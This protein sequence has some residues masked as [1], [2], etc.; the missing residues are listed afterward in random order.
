M[1]TGREGPAGLSS[2]QAPLGGSA[3]RVPAERAMWE[4]RVQLVSLATGE[5]PC[6]G[7]LQTCREAAAPACGWGVTG[8]GPA[9]LQVAEGQVV[10][11][12]QRLGS[13]RRDPLSPVGGTLF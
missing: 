1:G 11:G 4:A 9:P 6:G 10:P 3:G 13:S 8:G 7:S 12:R 5:D 2:H